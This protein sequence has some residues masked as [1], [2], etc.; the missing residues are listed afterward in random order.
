M[1]TIGATSIVAPFA[2][3][4]DLNYQT[5]NYHPPNI[6]LINKRQSVKL[7]LRIAKT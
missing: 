6:M 7:T 5:L 3:V 2:L 1:I 4:V